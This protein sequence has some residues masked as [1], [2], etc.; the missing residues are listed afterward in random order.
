MVRLA[1]PPTVASQSLDT[2]QSL[3]SYIK[4]SISAFEISKA[5]E[6]QRIKSLPSDSEEDSRTK[7]IDFDIFELQYVDASFGQCDIQQPLLL[8]WLSYSLIPLIYT[9]NTL[10]FGLYP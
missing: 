4:F 9:P 8:H 2:I 7:Q 1:F 6:L 5:K 3:Q 10:N